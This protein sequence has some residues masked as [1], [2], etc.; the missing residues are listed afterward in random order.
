M[1][2]YYHSGPHIVEHGKPKSAF[3]K[4]DLLEVD[5]AS[6][7]SYADALFAGANVFIGVALSSSTESVSDKVPYLLA[8]DDTRFWVT[9]AAAA[10]NA[11]SKFSVVDLTPVSGDWEV[12]NSGN[13]A[14]ALVWSNASLD[15][16]I[17]S[18][19]SDSNDSWLVISIVSA[20]MQGPSPFATG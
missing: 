3:S 12:T 19:N 10:A 15:E 7:L 4:G 2:L 6:S 1:A 8:N 11:V 20:V 18:R 16:D 14:M 17:V 5:S 13:T 9:A